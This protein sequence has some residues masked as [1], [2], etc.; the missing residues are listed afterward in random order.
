MLSNSLCELLTHMYIY[1][2]IYKHIYIYIKYILFKEGDVDP[3]L[4]S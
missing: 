3:E 2:Y 1:I 4:S